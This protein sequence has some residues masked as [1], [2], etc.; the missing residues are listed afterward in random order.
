MEFIYCKRK[1]DGKEFEVLEICTMLEV[2]YIVAE[3]NSMEMFDPDDFEKLFER[4]EEQ[5]AI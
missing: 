3:N 2:W 1:S 5:S 4:L